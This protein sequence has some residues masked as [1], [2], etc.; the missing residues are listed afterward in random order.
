MEEV[1]KHCDK[2]VN[3]SPVRWLEDPMARY[4]KNSDYSKFEDSVSKKLEDLEVL[5]SKTSNDCLTLNILT[6]EFMF[7]AMADMIILNFLSWIL[8]VKRFLLNAKKIKQ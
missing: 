6:W 8:F 7:S 1:V 5:D 3:V 2:V 4:K